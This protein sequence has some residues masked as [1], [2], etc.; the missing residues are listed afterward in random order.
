MEQHETYE[1]EWYALQTYSGYENKVKRDLE[2]RTHSMGMEDNIFRVVIPTE[3]VIEEK[4]G[5]VKEKDEELFPGYVLVEMIMTDQA[6][7]IVRNTQNVTGFIG[8]HGAGSKPAP[9]LPEEMEGILRMM[10][11]TVEALNTDAEVG[12]VVRITDGPMS[13]QQG[14]ITEIDP[15]SKTLKVSVEMF[16]RETEAEA[17]FD[18]VQPIVG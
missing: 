12:D 11:T 1:K 8:S 2:R 6:W 16:G 5:K 9:L 15:E 17:S 4:N 13:G 7:Y 18:Q 3:K 14:V 10:G